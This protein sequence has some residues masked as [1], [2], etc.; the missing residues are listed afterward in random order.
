MNRV[1]EIELD[2]EYYG[3]EQFRFLNDN[4]G[5]AEDHAWQ[6]NDDPRFP[7]V[8]SKPKFVG[9]VDDSFHADLFSA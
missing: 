9:W 4:M 8:T 3:R 1:Y 7:N 5:L 2:A 6:L